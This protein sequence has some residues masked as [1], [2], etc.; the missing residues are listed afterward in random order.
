MRI[1]KRSAL[2]VIAMITLL[3]VS[4][5]IKQSSKPNSAEKVKDEALAYLNKNYSDDFKAKE[6]EFKSWAYDF[7]TITFTSKKYNNQYLEVYRKKVDG[8]YTFSDDY[9]KLYM[10]DDANKYFENMAKAILGDDVVAKV[11]FTNFDRPSK[12]NNN[13][14]FSDYLESNQVLLELYVFG[15][16]ISEETTKAKYQSLL[17]ELINKRISIFVEFIEIN[18]KGEEK[19]RTTTLHDTLSSADELFIESKSYIIKKDFSINEDELRKYS[20][21]GNS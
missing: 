12:L 2:L 16:N 3:G 11:E 15:G 14:T 1:V 5:C 7:D 18:S 13:S 21:G 6:L 8:K 4:G 9:F 19:I 10:N 20:Q 17:S